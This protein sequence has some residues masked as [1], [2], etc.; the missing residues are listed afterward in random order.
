[1]DAANATWKQTQA[2]SRDTI[3]QLLITEKRQEV[4]ADGANIA[5]PASKTLSDLLRDTT[6]LMRE[7]GKYHRREA[8]DPEKS[9][10]LKADGTTSA[11]WH[12]HVGYWKVTGPHTIELSFDSKGNPTALTFDADAQIGAK[13]AP[14]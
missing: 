9:F 4:T 10:T 14:Q 8:G 5:A 6:W 2:P 13:A 12:K 1:M 3:Q 11:T 7:D